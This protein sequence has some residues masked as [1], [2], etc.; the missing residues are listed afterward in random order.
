MFH[1]TGEQWVRLAEALPPLLTAGAALSASLTSLLVAFHARRAANHAQQT[2]DSATSQARE[3]ARE[4][5]R[6]HLGEIV[7]Q[8]DCPS[9]SPIVPL[10]EGGNS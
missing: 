3:A 5:I 7:R 8:N 4:Q 9:N 2:A 1:L 6:F 10:K